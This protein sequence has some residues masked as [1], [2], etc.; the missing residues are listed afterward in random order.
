MSEAARD[1]VDIKRAEGVKVGLFRPIT[2]HPMD[3]KSLRKVATRASKIYIV[4]A[5]LNQFS[6][7]VKYELYGSR[8]PIVEISKPACGFTAEEIAKLLK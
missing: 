5:A 8:V 6:R 1:A 3:G 7:I 4:E 2:L